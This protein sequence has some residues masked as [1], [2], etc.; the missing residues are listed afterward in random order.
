VNEEDPPQANQF[1]TN[2]LAM[3]DVEVGSAFQ[4]LAQAM[5]I[6]AQALTTQAQAVTTHANR[7][8]V[9]HVNRNVN[10]AASRVRDFAIMNPPEFHG[11]KVEEDPQRF[12][13]EVY[14]VLDVMGVSP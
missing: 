10:S 2:P 9:T 7:D 4:M 3:S 12:I 14:K 6:Q 8:V 5:T 11:F 13:D 1:P